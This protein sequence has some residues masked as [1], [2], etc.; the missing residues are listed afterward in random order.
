[1]FIST[2]ADANPAP[3]AQLQHRLE[4]WKTAGHVTPPGEPPHHEFLL[5]V[6]EPLLPELKKLALILEEAGLHGDVLRG[7]EDDPAVGLCV[8]AFQAVLRLSPAANPTCHRAI[9]AQGSRT[10]N[11]LE[12]C[13]PYRIIARGGLEREFQT[14]MVRLLQR[15]LPRRS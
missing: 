6:Q 1:M 11:A 9:M 15:F 4:E 14:A 3:P 10:N 7:D 13:I 8:D 12:W 2:H 5:V